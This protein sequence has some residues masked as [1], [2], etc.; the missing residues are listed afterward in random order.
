[1]NY[2]E[3][4]RTKQKKIQF[5]QFFSKRSIGKCCVWNEVKNKNVNRNSS[6][7]PDG[8]LQGNQHK[9]KSSNHFQ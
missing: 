3:N 7:L 8:S 5:I 9:C 2:V 4:E 6:Q 1:M